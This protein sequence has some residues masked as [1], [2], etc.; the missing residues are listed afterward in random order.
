[1]S[2]ETERKEAI[3]W[4]ELEIQ[5]HEE[6]SA[7]WQGS[8][9]D[10]RGRKL[11]T[12]YFTLAITALRAQSEAERKIERV[13]SILRGKCET[14]PFNTDYEKGRA[15]GWNDARSVILEILEEG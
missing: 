3:R 11:I 7:K 9:E 6:L 5:M 10:G 1:M 13:E 15:Q 8:L 2:T 12:N 4:L 14:Y